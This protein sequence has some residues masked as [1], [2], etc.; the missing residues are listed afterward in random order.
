MVLGSLPYMLC[1]SSYAYVMVSVGPFLLKTYSIGGDKNGVFFLNYGLGTAL[2]CPLVG[3]L[4]SRGYG[5][6]IYISGPLFGFILMLVFYSVQYLPI[7]DLP[8]LLLPLLFLLGG[9]YSLSIVTVLLV[10]E[11]LAFEAGFTNMHLM[12]SYVASWRMIIFTGGRTLGCI[13]T[14]GLILDYCGFYWTTLTQCLLLLS[15]AVVGILVLELN[16]L[17][18]KKSF[19]SQESRTQSCKLEKRGSDTSI[20]SRT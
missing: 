17:L 12:N 6:Q 20:I 3:K 8:Y 19:Y 2:F 1:C 14:G 5:A 16:N 18:R 7:L 11:K 13:I 15:A 10:C 9:C 4:T